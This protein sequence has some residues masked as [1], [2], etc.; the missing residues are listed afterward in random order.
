MV[1]LVVTIP[2]YNEEK[3]IGDVIKGICRDICDDV[4]ILVLDDGSSDNT[5]RIAY[6]AGAD[7]V[8]SHIHNLGLAVTFKDS[9]DEALDMGADVI[10]N[11]DAD[12]Q[13]DPK[14]ISKLIEPVIRKDADVV[15]G[16][17]F[18]GYIEEMPLG[19]RLGNQMATKVI[20]RAAGKQFSDAQTGF[21]VFSR[22]AALRLNVMSD[23]T[24]TQETLLQAV[25]KNLR[26]HEIPVNF[27][28]REDKSRL[29][30]NIWN[31]AKR[32]S[33][34][35]LRTY[36]YHK[37]LKTFLMLGSFVFAAGFLLGFRVLIHYVT[38]SRVTPYL[39]TSVL[40]AVLLIVGFQI[41]ILGLVADLIRRN[42]N[43]QEEILYRLKK[44]NR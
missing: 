15:L 23:F 27:Y 33:Y 3:T 41:I 1:R 28:K 5:A 29:F 10:V 24:Y 26:I 40:S 11:I 21:R 31:Y 36:L 25:N 4:K 38:T 44:N 7:K 14:E 34:T 16:S 35:L 8:V 9:L 19:K 13:Y 30:P 43:V 12:G 32:A 18:D 37:P 22:D 39:P 17:R 2:A 20:S 42:Q 6:D